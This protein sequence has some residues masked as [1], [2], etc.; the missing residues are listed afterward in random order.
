MAHRLG[1]IICKA[2]SQWEGRMFS[3]LCMTSNII[4]DNLLVVSPGN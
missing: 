1:L 3:F 4:V 2:K